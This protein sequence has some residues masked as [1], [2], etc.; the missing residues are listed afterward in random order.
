M[1]I[2]PGAGEAVYGSV[3][4]NISLISGNL[5][6]SG[7][8]Q[9]STVTLTAAAN[10]TVVGN[11][12]VTGDLILTQGAQV[13]ASNLVLAP[14]ASLVV[15]VPALPSPGSSLQVVVANYSTVSGQYA[16]VD[17]VA[18]TPSACGI[19]ATPVYGPSSLTVTVTVASCNSLS[20]GALVG[21][22]IGSIVGGLLI[23]LAIVLLVRHLLRREERLMRARIF[24]SS[25]NYELRKNRLT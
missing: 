11:L 25:S 16:A 24:Q 13:V 22:I 6:V 21:I 5:L 17:A 3:V 2:L 8:L 1:S 20:T 7:T 12:T 10:V 9:L 15:N 18:P 4:L 19:T 23:A 14:G